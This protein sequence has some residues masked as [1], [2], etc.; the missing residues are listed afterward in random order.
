MFDSAGDAPSSV[1]PSR[2]RPDP[3]AMDCLAPGGQRCLFSEAVR[4][5]LLRESLLTRVVEGPLGFPPP[6]LRQHDGLTYPLPCDPA[7]CAAM[8]S[9]FGAFT[10]IDGGTR[11]LVPT[12]A[13][14][15]GRSS[16]TVS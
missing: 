14:N 5:V 6:A 7:A 9:R 1:V 10:V 15:V 8:E 11:K 4:V 3:L 2:C 12:A 13:L 16:A